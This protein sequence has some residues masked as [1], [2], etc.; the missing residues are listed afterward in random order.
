[1]NPILTTKD[2]LDLVLDEQ[3]QTYIKNFADNTNLF[4]AVK[5][6]LLAGLYEQGVV[7]K[8]RNHDPFLNAALAPLLKGSMITNEQLG[9][10]TRALNEGL[11]W[12]ESAFDGLENYKTKMVED[13]DNKNPAR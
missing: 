10:Y 8:H 5:K 4:E 12:I 11:R 3:E 7:K 2:Y 9:A 1:M 13:K 6:A